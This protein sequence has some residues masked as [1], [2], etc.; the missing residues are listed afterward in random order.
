MMRSIPIVKVF[1][2]LLTALV[3]VG[4][5]AGGG[6]LWMKYRPVNA[7][8][9][10]TRIPSLPRIDWDRRSPDVLHLPSD[11]R[12]S[13]KVQTA[14]A[15]PA[16]PPQSLRLRGSLMLDANRLA[17][18]KCFFPGQLISLGKADKSKRRRLAHAVPATLLSR[19]KSDDP[20]T[21]RAGDVVHKGQVLAIIWSQTVGEKKSELVDAVSRLETD[22]RLFDRY[23]R[24][25][26]GVI[27]K[28]DYDNARRNVEQDIIAVEKAERT[29]RSWHLSTDEIQSVHRE[30]ERIRERK[31]EDIA[32]V[33][34]SSDKTLAPSR[35]DAEAVHW[36]ET[37]ILSP[38]D[39]VI[40]E[41]NVTVGDVVDTSTDLFKIVDLSHLQVM[42]DAYEEDIAALRRLKPEQ[43]RW[44]I[45][46]TGAGA[47][48]PIEGE[49]DQIIPIIDP[50]QHTGLVTGWLANDGGDRLIGEFVTALVDLPPDPSL[51]A[52]P[53]SALI[54]EG[55]SASVLVSVNGSPLDFTPRKVAVVQRGRQ[56][57]LVRAE[58]NAAEKAR[59]AQ[60]LH[61]GEEVVTTGNLQLA[62]ELA[63]FKASPAGK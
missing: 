26:P 55:S 18:V 53:A 32:V 34:R 40:V 62:A 44:K 49:I 36:A 48:K 41:K 63:N 57:V 45:Q 47:D 9:S 35:E 30:A 3:I 8:E 43:M 28:K 1:L 10:A 11:Y 29:L 39:G 58:P 20:D 54:E 12:A 37:A 22:Q 14:R 6:F 46:L 33:R 27:A 25:D 16:P 50:T 5:A 15:E 38:I 24:V 56:T 51:V 61:A 21:L 52:I 2:R 23:R 7:T 60:S 13:L 19:T 42:A 31:A 59:G 17:R 4:G